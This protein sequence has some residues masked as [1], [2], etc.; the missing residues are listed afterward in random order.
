[1]FTSGWNRADSQLAVWSKFVPLM[2]GLLEAAADPA[3]DAVQL[4]V[5]DALPWRTLTSPGLRSL[6]VIKPDGSTHILS[7]DDGDEVLVDAPGIYT[8]TDGIDPAPLATY[9]VN[10]PL[11]ESNTAPMGIEQLEALGIPLAAPTDTPLAAALNPPVN[12][13]TIELEQRQRL[14]RWI[15]LAVVGLLLIETIWAGWLTAKNPA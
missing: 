14:W 15:L 12:L 8:L 10:L 11:A 2:N 5:G 4:T 6:Q 9:A 3:G 13:A 1:V 7:V